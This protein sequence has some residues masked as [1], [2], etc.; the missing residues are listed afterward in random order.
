VSGIS[1]SETI[2]LKVSLCY[3]AEIA[4]YVKAGKHVVFGVIL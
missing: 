2:P 4:S 3:F 1:V